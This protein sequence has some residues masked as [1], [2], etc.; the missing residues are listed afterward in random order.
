M[1]GSYNPALVVL[2][3]VIAACASYVALDLAGRVS[4]AR[5]RQRGIWLGG[6]ATAMGLG[7]W[8]MHY[9]GMEAF[10]LPVPVLYDLPTVLLSLLAA[11]LSSAVALYVVGR[12]RLSA[13]SAVAGS[14]TMGAGVSTMHYVGMEAMR[15][16]AT[17]AWNWTIVAISVVI[18][19][20]VSA[21]ALVLAFHFR[22]DTRAFSPLKWASAVLMGLAIAGMHYTGMA[23]A[24]FT[25]GHMHG[26]VSW[27][28]GVSALGLVGL[29]LV[30][31]M[32]LGLALVTAVV[33]RRLS[34]QAEELHASGERYQSL[35]DRCLA[36]VYQTT[37]GG[38]LVDCNDAF[39]KILGYSSREECLR[40][41]VM[42]AHYFTP[43]E[44]DDFVVNL[45]QARKLTGVERRLKHHDGTAI[46]VLVSATL[47]EDRNRADGEKIIEGS[48]I[49]ITER[50]QVEQA[51]RRASEHAE[52]ANRSKSEFLANM[53]HEIRTP[54]NGIIGMTE[55][56]LSTELTREQ[57][58]YLEM[59]QISAD[60]LLG[61]IN[62]ILDFSKIEARKLELDAI[63][64]DLGQ[65]VEDMMR[66]LA[67]RAHRQGLELAYHVS[68]DTPVALGGD[69][70]RLR[71]ILINLVSNAIKFTE[72]GE[73]VLWVSVEAREQERVTLHFA[74]HD[75]GIGISPDK[76]KTIF[77]AFAQADA[78]TTRRYGG[79]GLGLTI[80]TQ[81]T[82]LMGGR[83]WVES[84]PGQGSQFHVTV[85]FQTRPDA[86]PARDLDLSELADLSVLV[87][88]DNATNRRILHDALANWGMR[89]TTANDGDQAMQIVAGAREKGTPFGLVLLDHHMPNMTGL[90]VAER[91]RATRNLDATPIV[92]LTS[93]GL[94]WDALRATTL[95]I[96]ASLTK[97][98][99]RSV[100]LKAVIAA[101]SQSR[102]LVRPVEQTLATALPA[103]APSG[104]RVL[105]AEDNPVNTRVVTAMLEKHGYGVTCVGNGLE[106]LEAVRSSPFDIVLMDMQM[107]E[108]DGLE[109]T[110][111]IRANE[112]GTGRHLPIIAL[113]ARAMKGDREACEAAG[114]DGY[115]SKP[116]RVGELFE[117][118]RRLTGQPAAAQQP[119]APAGEAFDKDDV[120]ARVSGDRQLLAELV[121][122]FNQETPRALL[123]IR[124]SVDN[125]DATRLE[126]AAHRLRGSI[127]A[128]GADLAA[129]AALALES[130]G[131][132]GV[133]TEAHTHVAHL[134]REVQRLTL[135]LGQFTQAKSS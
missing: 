85:P 101:V 86:A 8:A 106:A 72:T 35:F 93:A 21:V 9:V 1:T 109:A 124:R 12:Q 24:T 76:Q 122:V 34:A 10:T 5:G 92:V 30:T 15:L 44:R 134:E 135:A 119:V 2:S 50:K 90:Q 18:A 97:P 56:A 57:R 13:T 79:T 55:L 28:V 68:P 25:P 40:L 64:F 32:V 130:L 66:S 19:I 132:G 42:S 22:G 69:P 52:A 110:R 82:N 128:F 113:T 127:M 45:L 39:A 4:A 89:P 131:R 60:S 129:Q 133:L 49:D 83:I 70:A 103:A 112:S 91:M 31:F 65:I 116:M 120:L 102:E 84:T 98:V 81:L 33:D 63:D 41:A 123:E 43:E 71:Q 37:P 48:L 99:R 47:V 36:G 6:G 73:V 3:L 27:A 59:V 23:A 38:R 7:I 62:D 11:V 107:P 20:V 115:L 75:T 61:L 111:R 16:E 14:L 121:D 53:S 74:V 87:V 114:T 96:S 67:V 29:V 108:M 54:M 51:L 100:L 95:G 58:E 117:M 104:V 78:S 88:D 80:A 77:D 126:R 105:V 46:W 118:I 94:E 26:D 17:C 125:N